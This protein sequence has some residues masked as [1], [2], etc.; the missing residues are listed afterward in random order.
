MT[1]PLWI[2]YPGEAGE[3]GGRAWAPTAAEAFEEI[4]A[5]HL[6]GVEPDQR[7]ELEAAIR[8]AVGPDDL[9]EADSG[10]REFTRQAAG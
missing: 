3:Y 10:E 9:V 8:E 7:E 5:A 6:S 4:V 1:G 2:L